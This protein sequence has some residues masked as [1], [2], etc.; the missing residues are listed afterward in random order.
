[1]ASWAPEKGDMK[2]T[3]N[4]RTY[5][6]YTTGNLG[7]R[8]WKDQSQAIARDPQSA[9]WI[10]EGSIFSI[11]VPDRVLTLQRSSAAP[12]RAIAWNTAL[13]ENK[14]HDSELRNL[15]SGRISFDQVISTDCPAAPPF[16]CG[17]PREVSVQEL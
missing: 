9:L 11:P 14:Q 16:V 5:I 6:N 15:L 10:E 17:V 13:Y 2:T 7:V 4:D 3:G 8:V 12:V 1:M